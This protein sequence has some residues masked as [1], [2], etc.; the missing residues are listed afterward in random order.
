MNGALR[1]LLACSGVVAGLALVAGCE[2]PFSPRADDV[3]DGGAPAV[4]L[5]NQ[6][7]GDAATEAVS[8][9]EEL[10]QLGAYDAA[11]AEFERAIAINPQMTVAYLGA[12]DIY[13]ER[14]EFEA[15]EQQYGVAARIEPQSFDAQFKHGLALQFLNRLTDA[16][17]A[18]LRALTLRPE[19]PEANLNLATAYLQL[20]EPGQG[21]PFAEKAVRLDG[22]SGPARANLGSTYAALGMHEAAVIEYQ[23]AAELMEL[24]PELLLNLAD[25][26]GQVGRH[27]E[28][29]ATLDQLIRLDPSAIA[30]ERLG[31]ALFRLRRYDEA[32]A[33]FRRGTELDGGHYPAW[34]GVGVCLLNR[35]LW[36]DRTDA[37]ARTQAVD[38]L[39]RSL[40]I[41][42]GQARIVE[43]V[44]R[45]D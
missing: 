18:Y 25:S 16:V 29:A 36:S 13:A 24:S 22:Q 23:Q 5:G 33:A 6:R 45:Y 1:R 7:A 30:Y 19:D 21:R 20:G 38:A 32:L 3:A 43:L 27:A 26:L 28:M 8:K 15:A 41:E 11:L 34:N 4:P 42:P 14:G 35:Y 12:G 37:A 39:R 2:N 10:A 31:S 9:G 40:R 44:R 17:R